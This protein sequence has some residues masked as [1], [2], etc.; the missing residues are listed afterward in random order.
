MSGWSGG[1]GDF[2]LSGGFGVRGGGRMMVVVLAVGK[3]VAVVGIGG[4]GMVGAVVVAV[5]GVVGRSR[6]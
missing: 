2:G 5:G 1:N 4:V 3:G 6:A